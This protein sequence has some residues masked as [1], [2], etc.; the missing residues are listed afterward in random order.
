MRGGV[1]HRQ[2]EE[3]RPHPALPVVD[4][5]RLRLE[6]GGEEVAV[7]VLILAPVL[8][9]LRCANRCG[10]FRIWNPQ[11]ATCPDAGR[12]SQAG[13]SE[14]P[15]HICSDTVQ[16]FACRRQQLHLSR[17]CARLEQRVQLL[18]RVLL[19]V[20]VDGNIAP[21]AWH[22][23]SARPA[24]LDYGWANKASQS[25]GAPVANL[26]RQVG[27]VCARAVKA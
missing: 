21:A 13:P 6:H 4:E 22:T 9:V 1:A 3:S 7:A 15:N 8:E 17:T 24:V 5:L 2:A 19:Q 10:K 12:L 25:L 18:V 23:S 26:L 14:L 16:A 20:A 11:E 27:S